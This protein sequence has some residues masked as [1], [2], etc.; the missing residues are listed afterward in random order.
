MA[1]ARAM[2]RHP[3]VHI[4]DFEAR[5]GTRFTAETIVALQRACPQARFVWLMGADNLAQFHQW[6]DWRE[7]LHR[8]PVG[9]L[10]RPGDRM[11]A[12]TAPAAQ[13]FRHARLAPRASHLLAQGVA[14]RWCFVNMPMVDV[15][16]TELRKAGHWPHG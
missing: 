4:S 3:R 7:I 9:V 16:S 10:A 1:A 13:M 2:M 14:P 15:S 5:A 12:R 6:K 8:V 11:E